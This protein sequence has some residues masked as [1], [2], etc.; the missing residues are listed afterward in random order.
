MRNIHHW[1]S[2]VMEEG[3]LQ[4]DFPVHTEGGETEEREFNRWMVDSLAK[5]CYNA[6]R[7]FELKVTVRTLSHAQIEDR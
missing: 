5:M 3:K 1:V 2:L 7:D 4:E 6:K